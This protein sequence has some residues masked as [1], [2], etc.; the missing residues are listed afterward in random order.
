MLV[1][2]A[3]TET[4]HEIANI[5]NVADI[6]MHTLELRLVIRTAM[7]MSHDFIDDCLAT[8]ARDWRFARRIDVRDNDPVSVLE[9][10]AEFFA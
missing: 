1:N 3:G 8:D 5:K 7:T 4:Q 9:C 10:A 2:I 6:P